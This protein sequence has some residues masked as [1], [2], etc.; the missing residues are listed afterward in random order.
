MRGVRGKEVLIKRRLED[1]DQY[2]A[3]DINN[4]MNSQRPAG[5]PCGGKGANRARL[6][7]LDVPG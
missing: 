5:T 3:V 1:A 4:Q 7:M 6:T 2:D